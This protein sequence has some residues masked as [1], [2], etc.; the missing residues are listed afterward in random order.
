[1]AD[2]DSSSL[3]SAPSSDDEEMVQKM[4][5]KPTGLDR[6]FKPAPKPE[7]TPEPPK[8]APSPPHEY[9]L[10]DNPAIAFIVMFRSRFSDV[11]PKSLPNYGPQDIERGVAGELPDEQVE[12]LLCA[13]LGLVLNRKKD[14]ERG[15]Y[16]RALEDALSANHSQWPTEWK[17]VN[18]LHGGKSFNNMSPEERLSLLKALVLWSLNSSE[19]V[20]ALIKESYKQTRRDDDRNQPRSVQPWFSD[21]YRRKYW[22]IEGQDDSH[23]RIYRENDGKTAKTNTWF[24][25]AGS[26]PDVMVLAD[27]FADEHSS[28][29]KVISDKLRAAIPRF[30]AG[31]EKRRRRD[32]RLARKAAF[33]RPEPGFSLYEGRTRGKRMRYTYSDEEYG[34]DGLSSKRS[35]RNS[36]ISTPLETGPTVTASGRH[37]KSRVGGL[38]GESMLIDQ[39]KELERATGE[40][41]FTETSEDMPNT[42]PISRGVRTSRSGRQVK[43]T[44]QGYGDQMDSDESDEAQ[45]SGKEWSGNEDEPDESEPDFDGEDEGDDDDDEVMSD[46]G[47]EPDEVEEDENTQESLVVQLRYRKETEKPASTTT[48]QVAPPQPSH[49]TNGT[50]A[51]ING[52]HQVQAAPRPLQPLG[53]MTD[54]NNVVPRNS[55]TDGGQQNLLNGVKMTGHDSPRPPP[56][57][58]IPIQPMDIS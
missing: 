6:Y 10:A 44:R 40:G 49:M 51:A 8:R 16:G 53:E 57:V 20:Q 4:S 25:V 41:N 1:M 55:G 39:R 30:E 46:E 31:E 18:P 14:V 48:A 7:A 17:G 3:S 38:Y 12:R 56:T 54:T 28:N 50:S 23:F 21:Q 52:L 26:I 27:K 11:F 24:S 33:A 2:S 36:G 22:L 15:H 35:A 32:Y 58:H 45:S 5:L 29:S 13:L 9:T 47:L 34:S 43:P 42:M 37:V 19:A